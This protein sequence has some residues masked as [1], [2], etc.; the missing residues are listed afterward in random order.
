MDAQ[1]LTDQIRKFLAKQFPATKKAGIEDPLLKNGLID[2]LG[3]LEV[4]G[5]LEK[6]FPITIADEELLPENFESISCI[7][8]FVQQKLNGTQ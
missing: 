8:Q 4:V 7:C 2:S 5:F 1:I 3:I 6:E